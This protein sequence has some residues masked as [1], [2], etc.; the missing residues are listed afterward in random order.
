MSGVVVIGVGNRYRRDDGAGPAVLDALA[1]TTTRA[2]RDWSS[3]TANRHASSRRGPEPISQSWSTPSSLV[4]RPARSSVSMP[5]PCPP[6]ELRSGA[7]RSAWTTR[8]PSAGRSV[9]CPGQ[10]LVVVGVEGTA[11][12]AGSPLSAP[13]A[14]ALPR[15]AVAA[16]EALISEVSSC[17]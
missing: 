8:S 16:V 17:A 6:V 9:V 2:A 5:P 15:T 7:T 14:A 1:A 10:A 13:V 4:R 12:A 11:F 3:S